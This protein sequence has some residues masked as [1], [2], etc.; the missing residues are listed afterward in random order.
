MDVEA[1]KTLPRTRARLASRALVA[2]AVFAVSAA[3]VVAIVET[4]PLDDATQADGHGRGLAQRLWWARNKLWRR[5]HRA[6]LQS[7]ALEATNPNALT[8][9]V[10]PAAVLVSASPSQPSLTC[11]ATSAVILQARV[12]RAALVLTT[13]CRDS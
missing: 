2:L 10:Q 11:D 12:A 9:S 6:R 13:V 4:V 8:P 3:A 1:Q 5:R 7:A